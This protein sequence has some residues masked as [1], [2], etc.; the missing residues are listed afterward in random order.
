VPRHLR[1][2]PTR[3]MKDLGYADGYKYDHDFPHHFAGQPCLP[4]QIADREYYRPSDQGVEERIRQRLQWLREH[5][6][7][8]PEK[9]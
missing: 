4:P 7:G 3:L 2:A 5:R 1:N 6:D 8:Y 9:D